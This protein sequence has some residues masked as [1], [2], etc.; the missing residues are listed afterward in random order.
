M[1]LPRRLPRSLWWLAL[2]LATLLGPASHA[3]AVTRRAFATSV[4]NVGNLAGW[5]ESGF[6]GGLSGGDNVCRN[7]ATD[8]GLPNA[9]TYRAWLSTSTTDAYCHVQGLSGKKS[10]GC[11]G[12][13]LPGGGPWFL[14]N[15][16]TSWSG[17]LDELTGP[18]AILYRP[19]TADEKGTLITDA[20]ASRIWTGTEADG[21]NGGNDTCS[22]W[23]MSPSNQFGMT[24]YA[25]GTAQVWTAG[26][27]EPCNAQH[28]L[29]CMEPGASESGALS[30]IQP[31]ALVFVTS[32]T[33]TATLGSWP[34]A[35]GLTGIAAGDQ[36][37][38]SLADDAGL[39]APQSFVAW[40]STSTTDARDRLTLTSTPYR[41]LDAFLVA[42]GRTDLTDGATSNSIHVDE[43]GRYLNSDGG[44]PVLTATRGDG[45]YAGTG[46]CANWTTASGVTTAGLA[47]FSRNAEWTDRDA[48][49]ACDNI[50]SRLYCFANAITIF[51][52]R[53][54]YTSDLSRWSSHSP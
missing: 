2:V 8:A 9:N 7:L 37:C 35:D 47:A 45:T 32:A 30:W 38:R 33:G 11:G 41:R 13:A 3:G 21:T 27:F 19:I 20:D 31:A 10:T 29:L 14:Y 52:D 16:I 15:G 50:G 48:S 25:V 49:R 51:W 24:G 28:R 26:V 43:R 53:F 44:A 40:L 46:T 34:A 36:I 5:P 4:A 1:T 12:G 23:T 17:T 54:D 6:V 22:G 42:N 39:P 18:E